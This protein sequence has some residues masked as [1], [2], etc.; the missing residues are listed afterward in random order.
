MIARS[1]CRVLDEIRSVTVSIENGIMKLYV[2][3]SLKVHRSAA[4]RGTALDM[5][6]NNAP[7][8]SLLKIS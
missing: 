2:W 3:K 1:E 7:R 4:A 8:K 6:I 5:R